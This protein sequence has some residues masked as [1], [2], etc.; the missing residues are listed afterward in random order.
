M[1]Q[2]LL[3]ILSWTAF[4]VLNVLVLFFT[5]RA[6]FTR[7]MP[8]LQFDIPW[9]GRILY[10]GGALLCVVAIVA[11]ESC[12]YLTM[13]HHCGERVSLKAAVETV[14]LGKYFDCVTPSGMG[15]Q[16]FQIWNLHT[17]GYSH[18]AASAMPLATFITMQYSF[19]VL[20]VV[21]LI[22]GAASV[23][24]P[25][26]TQLAWVGV[27]FY[28]F[29]PTLVVIAAVSRET[30]AKIVAFFIRIGAK[31]RLVKDPEA[32]AEKAS[33]NIGQF[34]D[35]LLFIAKDPKV[36]LKL[37]GLSFVFH[38]ALYSIPF[39]VVR[40]LGGG[41]GFWASWAA[42]IIVYA[43]VTVVPTPGN[44]GAAE[45][46]FY[47]LFSNLSPNG[48]FWAMLIWR[49]LSYYIFVF[50]GLAVYGIGSKDRSKRKRIREAKRLAELQ[51]ESGTTRLGEGPGFDPRPGKVIDSA[52]DT[53]RTVREKKEEDAISAKGE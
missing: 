20:A 48:A 28:A 3:K 27:L 31:L 1:K 40:L 39:F 45:G 53:V 8:P 2:R 33:D 9:W 37:F 5:A 12:K 13:M 25:G 41:I 30:S 7:D 50:V 47:L 43:S 15:G 16:P 10:G 14:I 4:I 17:R 18:A 26:I 36:L 34:A 19:I 21:A 35:G 32:T 44:A 38:F 29:V 22:F 6:E 24:L 23:G 51:G 11:A 49:F 42:C 46:S 52:I